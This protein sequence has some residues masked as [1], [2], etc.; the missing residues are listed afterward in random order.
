MTEEEEN[1][2]KY[3]LDFD[4]V[5]KERVAEVELIE[6]NGKITIKDNDKIT[7]IVKEDSDN[8]GQLLEILNSLKK[9]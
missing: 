3:M 2:L 8:Y 7:A 4:K 9:V 5:P 1:G 6:H